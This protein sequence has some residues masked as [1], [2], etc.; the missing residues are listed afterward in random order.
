MRDIVESQAR[1]AEEANL[2]KSGTAADVVKLEARL[3]APDSGGST[4]GASGTAASAGSG[5]GA[6]AAPASAVVAV[7]DDADEAAW[8]KYEPWDQ[9]LE[10]VRRI[11]VCARYNVGVFLTPARCLLLLSSL[12]R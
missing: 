3:Q 12:R 5:T 4:E 2:A 9:I 1:V 10:A 7:D 11:P 8:V 6:S